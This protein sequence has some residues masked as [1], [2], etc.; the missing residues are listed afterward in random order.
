MGTCD[1]LQFVVY[2][3]TGKH[4][5]GEIKASVHEVAYSLLALSSRVRLKE[6][7]Q[8]QVKQD[9]NVTDLWE[10]RQQYLINTIF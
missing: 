4:K 9:K 3:A 5:Y 1:I 7:K 2:T 6:C 10:I 8:L